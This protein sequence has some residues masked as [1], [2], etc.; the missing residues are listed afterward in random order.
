MS[1]EIVE[2]ISSRY[3][4]DPSDLGGNVPEFVGGEAE[5]SSG[6]LL[7]WYTSLQMI[8]KILW[9]ASSRYAGDFRDGTMVTAVL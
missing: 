7:E 8:V 4:N 2:R 6:S 5:V 1:K 9:L 3:I